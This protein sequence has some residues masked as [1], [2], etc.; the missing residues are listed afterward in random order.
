MKTNITIVILWF[1]ASI[2]TGCSE[3]SKNK[4]L[5][6]NVNG[7]MS[8]VTIVMTDAY[9]NSKAG[10]TLSGMLQQV[11][12]YLPQ[13]EPMFSIT[14]INPQAFTDLVKRSRTILQVIISPG[15]DKSKIT[16]KEDVWARPQLLVIIESGDEKSFLNMIEKHGN[17]ILETLNKSE[18]KRL[19]ENNSKYEEKPLR[20]KVSIKHNVEVTFPN[21]FRLKTDTTNF[22]WASLESPETS[23]GV[24][25]YAYPYTDTLQLQPENLIKMRDSLL[26]KFVPGPMPKSFM[27][28]EP[29]VD[30][31]FKEFYLDSIYTAEIRG[32]WSVKNDFMG[33]PFLSLTQIDIKNSR[34]VTVEGY[35]YAPRF[36]KRNYMRQIEAIVYSMKM[37]HTK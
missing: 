26:R 24:F 33:G 21:G 17:K 25:V 37:A 2:L 35:V 34:I 16:V 5:M 31:G 10:D 4:I 22:T 23:Q 6:P 28:T 30:P 1:V 27:R 29:M 11:F 14:R 12:P 15:I 19:M 9:W 20:A 13:A 36:D 32:L 3:D 7:R 18:R 8:D